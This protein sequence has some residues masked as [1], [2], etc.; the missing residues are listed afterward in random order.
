MPLTRC[1]DCGRRTKGSRCPTCRPRHELARTRASGRN[2]FRWR[3]LREQRKRI[4]GYRCTYCGSTQDLTVDLDPHLR[5]N[6]RVATI[7]D[8]RTACRS[9]RAEART[10]WWPRRA[11]RV[12]T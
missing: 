10:Q 2:T 1:L 6:H 5:G 3:Q 9:C 11:P 8:C 12:P 4:D 7:N